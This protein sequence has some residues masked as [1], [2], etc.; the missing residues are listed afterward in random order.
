MVAIRAR[1]HAVTEADFLAATHKVVK[2]Y[3]KFSSSE[4]GSG[5]AGGAGLP[6]RG[7]AGC[8]SCRAGCG[9]CSSPRTRS[10]P[11]SCVQPPSTWP[12][13]TAERQQRSP[14]IKPCTIPARRCRDPTLHCTTKPP[15][16]TA[17]SLAL[18]R[19]VAS[20]QQITQHKQAGTVMFCSPDH[21]FLPL[22][23]LHGTDSGDT[24]VAAQ[25]RGLQRRVRE[26]GAALGGASSVQRV[27]GGAPRDERSKRQ[28][29]WGQGR[30]EG[31]EREAASARRPVQVG[32][33][34]ELSPRPSLPLRWPPRRPRPPH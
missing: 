34:G 30:E 2:E 14:A 31:R 7:P 19:A 11:S 27:R 5:A 12:L 3:Q 33:H 10:A 22:P 21:A 13:R 16:P 18:P 8:S 26:R 20:M 25:V 32:T 1:R 29:K 4:C 15:C 23:R 17:L 6:A 24:S 28:G 9:A